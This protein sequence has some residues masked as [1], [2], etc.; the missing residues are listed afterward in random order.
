MT[1]L[2]P[3]LQPARFM[4]NRMDNQPAMRASDADREQTARLLHAAAVDGRLTMAE[5]DERLRETYH[6]RTLAELIPITRDLQPSQPS[7]PSQPGQSGPPNA[8]VSL[9]KTTTSGSA[10]AIGYSQAWAVLSEVKRTGQWVVPERFVVGAFW[11]GAELDLRQAI[12]SSQHITIHA[13]AIMAGIEI[14]VPDDVDVLCEGFGLMGGF[15][16]K[17]PQVVSGSRGSV[18]VTGLAFWGGVQIRPASKKER[19]RLDR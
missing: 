13:T 9:S 12:F 3:N 6:S 17:A 18:R 14:I 7:Q 5:L 16:S 2:G 11:G 8:A 10:G 4:L 1:K 15:E 19:K